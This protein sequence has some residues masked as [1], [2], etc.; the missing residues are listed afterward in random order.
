MT[1]SGLDVADQRAATKLVAPAITL[2]AFV[3]GYP[4]IAAT[5]LSLHREIIV[6]HERRFVGL[7]NYAWLVRDP[8]FRSALGNTAYFAAAS[9]T[10]ECA[11]GLAFALVLQHAIRGR[12]L[13]RVA[14]LL[15]WAIPTVVSAQLW[16]F[17]L[18]RV[19]TTFGLESNILGTPGLAMHAAIV[20]DAWKST[21]FVALLLLAGLQ[22]IP[23]D[24]YRAARID[25]A[26]AFRT[27][28]SITLPLLRPS[29]VVAVLFRLLDAFRVFD[30]I[31][32]LTG[33]GPANTTETLSIHA[34]KTLMR[35][36]DFGYGAALSVAAF[37][38]VMALS[39]IYLTTVARHEETLA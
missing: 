5:W 26:S 1:R 38:C 4:L 16:R 17:M 35:A 12:A 28:R 24:L 3:A 14:V 7:A 25:G 32:V 36:G 27:F 31:F 18:D 6:L 21:P 22:T 23:E 33:G 13:L 37:V 39:A 11:L 20:V 29:L 9:V 10:L 34:Y 2:L 15:P 8:R 19:A 30:V